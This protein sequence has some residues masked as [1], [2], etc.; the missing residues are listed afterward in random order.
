[1]SQA[2]RQPQKAIDIDPENGIAHYL[3][4]IIYKLGSRFEE[5]AGELEIITRDLP[6]F[7]A[8]HFELGELLLRI[9]KIRKSKSDFDALCGAG[10]R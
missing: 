2:Y 4:S 8:A 6:G 9:R 10:E 7:T 1:M 5:A 3:I